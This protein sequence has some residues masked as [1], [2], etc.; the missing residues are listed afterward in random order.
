MVFAAG[1]SAD[2]PPVRL[3]VFDCGGLSFPD[4]SAFGLNNSDTGVRRMF[5]PCYLIRHPGGDLL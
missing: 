4:I 3:H 1:D 2:N 5:V